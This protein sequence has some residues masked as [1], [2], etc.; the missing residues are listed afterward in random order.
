MPMSLSLSQI[1]AVNSHDYSRRNPTGLVINKS[2]LQPDDVVVFCSE[3]M[4]A[5]NGVRILFFDLEPVCSITRSVNMDYH[6]TSDEVYRPN[7]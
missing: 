1:K 2:A 4:M 6:E 7:S 5:K 3:C